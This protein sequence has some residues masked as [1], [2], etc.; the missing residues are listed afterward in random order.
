MGP[1]PA[2]TSSAERV[3]FFTDA[4][5]AIALTLLIL[6]LL[7]HVSAA[8]SEGLTAAEFLHD[9]MDSLWVFVFSF[10]MIAMFWRMHR[11]LF[12]GVERVTSLLETLN[13][14]W[15][16]TIV[17]M[18]VAFALVSAVQADTVQK[19]V[20]VGTMMANAWLL[21]AMHLEVR[22]HPELGDDGQQRRRGGLAASLALAVLYTVALGIAL[23]IPGG[24]GYFAMMVMALTSPLQRLIRKH[25]P[26]DSSPV[27]PVG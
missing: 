24:A 19:L 3:V 1:R 15:M 2:R 4:V 26:A 27:L 9:R 14:A 16:F 12:E 18:P 20:Y 7:E 11:G 5:V 25:L 8:G 17:V 21:V 23:L 13:A 22:R 6:P 10:V